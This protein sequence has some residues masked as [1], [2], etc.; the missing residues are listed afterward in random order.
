MEGCETFSDQIRAGCNVFPRQNFPGWEKKGGLF[1]EKEKIMI[2]R[3]G[4]HPFSRDKDDRLSGTDLN[5]MDEQRF[6]HIP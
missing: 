1:R 4:L 2:E 3:R 6:R 5:K